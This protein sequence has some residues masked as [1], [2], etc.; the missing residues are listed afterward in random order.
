MLRRNVT[1]LSDGEWI[2][3]RA[4][5]SR[6]FFYPFSQFVVVVRN[7]GTFNYFD[8]SLMAANLPSFLITLVIAV[9]FLLPSARFQ[10][11]LRVNDEDTALPSREMKS[12]RP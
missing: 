10:D 3:N 12:G 9:T 11:Y 5:S 4:F 1:M 8:Y 7:P 6:W 2:E